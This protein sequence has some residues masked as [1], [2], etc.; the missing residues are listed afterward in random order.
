MWCDCRKQKNNPP[1]P[2]KKKEDKEKT[3]SA[4]APQESRKK[5]EWASEELSV[6]RWKAERGHLKRFPPNRSLSQ[7]SSRLGITN[8]GKTTRTNT[9]KNG[10]VGANKKTPCAH[11]LVNVQVSEPV[12]L[13][14]ISLKE[15]EDKESRKERKRE[16]KRQRKTN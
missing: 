11:Y 13:F 3:E 6:P 5:T 15:R 9:T 7:N 8:K 14:F 12:S 16:K 2:K 10:K 1:T 4:S